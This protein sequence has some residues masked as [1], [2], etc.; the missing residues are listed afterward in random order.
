MGGSHS[1][2]HR[3][4]KRIKLGVA[5]VLL[6]ACVGVARALI[7]VIEA[8][9][10]AS[11]IWVATLAGASCWLAI[12]LMLPKPMTLYVF[13][14]ELTHA[15]WAWLFGGKVKR[16]KATAK[17]GHVVVTKSNF[18]ITLAPY[19]FPIY[20][21]AAIAVFLAG[22]LIWDWMRYAVYFHVLVGASYAFHVTLTCHVLKQ[23][24]SD[25]V[26][27]GYLFSAV[28]I[29]LSNALVLLCGIPLLTRQVSV[30]SALGWA[31]METG[32]VFLRLSQ[33]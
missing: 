13:G 21:A 9:G 25:I 7:R 23:R 24:Q 8:S 12:F 5:I 27:E 29:W 4:S 19:F 28:I 30:L 11:N 1:G 26:E 14:H 17:G 2:N 10:N 33:L 32:K 6:P 18:I 15:L 3:M 22:H 20:T 31:W 16:F